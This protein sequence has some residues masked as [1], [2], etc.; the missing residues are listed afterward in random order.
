MTRG[1]PARDA[2][3]RTI[4]A[5]D[6]G[7]RNIGVAV[8]QSLTRTATPLATLRAR[9]AVPE[10]AAL[11]RLVEGWQ[12][13]AMVVGLPLNMDGTEQDTTRLARR[14][15]DELERRFGVPVH[16]VDERLSTREAR[17]R[18][19]R[20]GRAGADDD[21]VAAQV[22][23]E[24]WFSQN[25]R[26][27]L[28][29]PA[30][31]RGTIFEEEARILEH[32]RF[33]AG[34]HRLR[35]QSPRIAGTAL[36]GSFVHVR[37]DALLP[38]RR[39][40]SIL[41][42]ERDLG[43]VDLLFKEVGTGTRLLARK[44]VGARLSLLGPIGNHFE[45][46]PG[47]SRPLLLGGGVGMPPVVFLARYWRESHPQLSPLVLLGSEVP[48]P[49]TVCK[50]SAAPQ[51]PAGADAGMEALERLGVASRLASRA[52]LE[53]C[54]PGHVTDLARDWLRRLP[55]EARREVAVYACGPVAMLEAAAALAD[56]YSLPAQVCLEEYMA[57][58]VGGCAGCAVRIHGPSGPAMRRVCV[59]GPVFDAHRVV[60]PRAD[61]SPS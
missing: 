8:G 38:M 22:I 17:E 31:R 21:P 46:L 52:G 58:A 28:A 34:Q 59:D 51:L 14:F 48:F 10:W 45:A 16:L 13:Q 50:A 36:P 49:F 40:M 7:R 2:S 43:W 24:D 42:A 33:E 1:S 55:P 23:L 15:R 26:R 11:A 54:Y 30:S 25:S 61:A 5:F 39:P 41:E 18:L 32:E 12:P 44:E 27:E 47:S 9:D 53:G 60:W 4:L 37:C 56:E 35:M 29:T 19:A 6:H 20:S 3:P 57:C